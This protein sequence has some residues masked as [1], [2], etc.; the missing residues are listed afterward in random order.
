MTTYVLDAE[1]SYSHYLL[2]KSIVAI[3][4][5]TQLQG[6]KGYVHDSEGRIA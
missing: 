1:N 2:C 5:A 3:L 4:L 6:T